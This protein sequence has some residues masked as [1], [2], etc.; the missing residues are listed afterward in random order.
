MQ[1]YTNS[2]AITQYKSQDSISRYP[3]GISVAARRHRKQICRLMDTKFTFDPRLD[4]PERSINITI[5][6]T[7]S[8]CVPPVLSRALV[9][10]LSVPSAIARVLCCN[11]Q[12]GEGKLFRAFPGGV[13]G[14]KD[15]LARKYRAI[16]FGLSDPIHRQV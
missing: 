15:N 16:S 1:R 10:S 12:P 11:Y 2:A 3:V 5:I 6:I 14:P 4:P 13:K 7:N 9:S 8:R